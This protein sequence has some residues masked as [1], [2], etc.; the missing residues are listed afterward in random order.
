MKNLNLPNELS[1]VTELAKNYWWSWNQEAFE[2]FNAFSPEKWQSTRNPYATIKDGLENNPET[3][4]GLTTNQEYLNLLNTTVDKMNTYVKTGKHPKYQ[5]PES[6]TGTIAYFCAEYGIHESLP[7]YSGGLGVLAGDHVKSASDL[8]LPLLFVGLYYKNGYFTQEIDSEGQQQDIYN[9]YTPEELG[10]DEV[11]TP[12]GEKLTLNLTLADRQVKV[13]VWKAQVGRVPLYLLDSNV[14]GN[15]QEDKDLTA[16][17]YGGDREMRISQ[18]IILGIGGIQMLEALDIH[19][20]AYHMNEGHSGFFQLERIKNE[21]K[22]KNLSFEEA[23]ILC[24]S[25]CL[26]TTHTP[27]PAGNEAFTLP[28][29]H[30]YFHNYI[31]E[32]DISWHRF[33]G[34]GLVEQQTDHKYF[35]L[36]VFA[37]NVSRFY[38]GVSALHGKIAKRMWSRLWKDVPTI[39]NPISSITNGVHTQTWMAKDTK[40]LLETCF[41][42][43]WTG[44]IINQEFW[45]KVIEVP[46]EKIVSIKQT[47]KKKMVDLVRERQAQQYLRF[48]KK[49][50]ATEAKNYLDDKTLTI[51]FARRFATYKRATLIFK[52]LDRLAKIVNNPEKPVQFIF[53]GKAHPQD[54]PGQAFIKEIHQISQR[55]EFRGKIIMLEGYDMN[56]SSHMVSGVDVWLNNP[57][58]PMEASGTSGQKVPINFGL[59]FS[60]LDGWWSEGYNEKNGWTIGQEKDYPTDEVQDFEDA[61]D[62]YK[63]LEQ[64]VAPLYYDK[65]D[66]WV[67][68][69]KEAFISTI[70]T[71]STD[72]MV[73]DYAE[74]F[75]RKACSY[76]DTFL[77]DELS[78]VKNYIEDRRFIQRNWT[79]TA[80]SGVEFE[81]SAIE[82]SSE[83][84]KYSQS[85]HHHVGFQVDETLPGRVFESVSTTVKG[86]IYLGEIKPENVAVELVITDK[87]KD[88][89][90]VLP[91]TTTKTSTEGLY[92]LGANFT[93]PDG[94]PRNLRLRY[95]PTF[96]GLQNKFELGQSNW[97]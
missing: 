42:G 91:V 41:G 56:I 77:K 97:L 92:T 49:E 66:D 17:L 32:F 76:R 93:S 83:Y 44:E 64:T 51:G 69:C 39:D 5:T 19:P 81:G 79:T 37:I 25:N 30:K 7:I 11:K 20:Q 59:N 6:I 29:M 63:T 85:P 60:V 45:N 16:R 54:K 28:L 94:R 90:E 73:S 8:G 52:D 57:R 21:M 50:L 74:K 55:D 88:T 62:F 71:Y 36:T 46:N 72:R 65:H 40:D 47:M 78:K 23:K 48:D 61:N 24:A 1:S 68:H 89:M 34:L 58:R 38:N 70:T 9:T 53:A 27:V 2:I 13:Q 18:E 84:Q 22:R 4:K 87:E 35:S 26:F 95:F 31:Q 43:E 67:A 96:D 14:E 33:V 15:T 86:E 75:Y 3:V 10:L 12:T 80:L 82:V